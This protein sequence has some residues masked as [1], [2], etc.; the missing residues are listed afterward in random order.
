MVADVV[1]TELD[2]ET[3]VGLAR[4]QGHDTSVQD[5]NVEAVAL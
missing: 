2:V 1:G 3:G 4:W 5:E